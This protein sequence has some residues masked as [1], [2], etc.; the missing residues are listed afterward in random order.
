M[1]AELSENPPADRLIQLYFEAN[2]WWSP[3][4]RAHAGPDDGEED[5]GEWECPIDFSE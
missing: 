5:A 4:G 3:P 1:Q 2:K